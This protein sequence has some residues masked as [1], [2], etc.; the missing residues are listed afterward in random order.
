MKNLDIFIQKG[1]S[2]FVLI[3]EKEK[4]TIIKKE[5]KPVIERTEKG[6]RIKK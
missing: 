6:F 5:K 2:K 3:R 1:K 4:Y